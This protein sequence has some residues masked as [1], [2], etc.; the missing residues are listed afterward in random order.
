[1]PT[2]AA[3]LTESS[4]E[5]S[6][7]SSSS[8]GVVAWT[9]TAAIFCPGAMSVGLRLSFAVLRLLLHVACMLWTWEAS[10]AEVFLGVLFFFPFGPFSK[11]AV[12]GVCD[13]TDF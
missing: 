3:A 7:S 8:C 12:S 4:L 5:S 2:G 9:A 11:C 13:W 1:M 10:F 6:A